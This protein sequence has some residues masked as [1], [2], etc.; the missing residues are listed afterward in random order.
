MTRIR[1]ELMGINRLQNGLRVSIPQPHSDS[2]KVLVN[3]DENQDSTPRCV[4]VSDTGI[5]FL[6][7]YSLIFS[8]L[9]AMNMEDL[10]DIKKIIII[11]LLK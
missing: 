8:K 9:P 2:C 4:R 10:G 11:S 3:T 1:I 7:F 5:Y 6:V